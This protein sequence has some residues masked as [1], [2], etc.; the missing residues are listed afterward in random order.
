MALPTNNITTLE[1]SRFKDVNGKV[2]VRV[3]DYKEQQ[4]VFQAT[5]TSISTTA[6]KID[7][8][9]QGTD[10]TIYHATSGGI[11]WIGPNSSITAGGSGTAPLPS[12]FKIDVSVPE[13]NENDFYA[14]T[15]EGTIIVYVIGTRREV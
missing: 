11:L 14:I 13:G 15:A 1:K 9:E 2:T 6:T 3:C 5:A 7:F 4:N 8:P 10:F 12:E